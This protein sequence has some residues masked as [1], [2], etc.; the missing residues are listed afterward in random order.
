MENGKRIL[1]FNVKEE[2][3]SQIEN[4]CAQLEFQ[5]ISV[6]KEQYNEPL[7][8]LAG[9]KGT[10]KSSL[11]YC[12]REFK[13]DML[14][15]YGIDSDALDKFL[16]KYRDAGIEP[17]NLKAVITFRNMFWSAKKLYGELL[18]EHTNL[19]GK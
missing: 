7:G 15:L 12:G 9:I 17:I 1:L 10:G 19:N 16:K 4:L 8:A 3:K 6:S 2:K 14:V 18:K 11:P 13:T 5:V